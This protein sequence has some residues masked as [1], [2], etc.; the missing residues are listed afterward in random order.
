MLERKSRFDLTVDR[1][2]SNVG[3]APQ[4]YLVNRYNTNLVS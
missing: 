4:G 3:N 1:M 2:E